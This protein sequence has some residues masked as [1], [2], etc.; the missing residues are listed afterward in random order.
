MKNNKTFLDS[1]DLKNL[2]TWLVHQRCKLK[3]GGLETIKQ[4]KLKNLG[5][6]ENSI[7]NEQWNKMFLLL[8][9]Y[10]EN[11]GNCNVPDEYK[12][13][14][15]LGKWVGWQR[16]LKTWGKLS[17][18]RIGRLT[19]LGFRWNLYKDHWDEMYRSLVNF[20]KE[21]GHCDIPQDYPDNQKL[22]TWVGSRRAHRSKLSTDEVKK[23][24]GIGFIWDALDYQWK[25]KYSVLVKYKEINGNCNIPQD[26]LLSVWV[27][28][29][30]VMRRR[31]TLSKE[32]ISAL[33]K[34]GFQWEPHSSKWEKQYQ[35]LINFKKTHGHCDVPHSYP[36]DLYLGVW[37][38]TQ[39]S[40]RKSGRLKSDRVKKLNKLGFRWEYEKEDLFKTKFNELVKFKTTHGHCNVPISYTKNKSLAKWVSKRRARKDSLS[41]EN[42]SLLDSLGFQWKLLDS[43]WESQYQKLANFKNKN[44]HCNVP[45]SFKENNLGVWAATQRSR[46]K[47]GTMLKDQFKKLNDIG[48]EWSPKETFLDSTWDIRFEEL[49]K[50]HACFGHC[51]VP[52]RFPENQTL[53]TWVSNLRNRADSKTLS[54]DKI[55]KL[56]SLNFDW[57]PIENAWNKAYSRLVL[58]HKKNGHCLVPQ[59]YPE[60]QSLG[61]WVSRQRRSKNSLSSS[62]VKLLESLG[63]VWSAIRN[64]WESMYQEL[65]KFKVRNIHCKVPIVYIENP[66]L[67]RWVAIQRRRQKLN[68]ISSGEVK[69][70]NSIG[71][72]WNGL[73]SID[74]CWEEM[75]LKLK[76]Y[77][78][79]HGNCNAPE[80][81]ENRRSLGSWCQRQRSCKRKGIIEKEKENRLTVLGFDWNP[82][83]TQFDTMFDKL[84]QYKK[85]YGNCDLLKKKNKYKKLLCWTITLR[86][87]YKDGHLNKDRIKRLENIGFVWNKDEAFSEKMYQALIQFKKEHGNCRVPQRY[88]KNLHLGFWVSNQR[89]RYKK[90]IMAP[91]LKRKLNALNFEWEADSRVYCLSKTNSAWNEIVKHLDL[92]KLP[93][94]I[95]SQRKSILAKKIKAERLKKLNDLGFKVA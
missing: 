13:N 54:R 2:S 86:Q 25:E 50:F 22:A 17:K 57:S 1:L 3:N 67:G 73:D 74:D 19:N 88:K 36:E 9:G 80:T 4:E 38:T 7:S 83:I 71:F 49:K 37:V 45:Q 64:R 93:K 94:W 6:K 35:E 60:D 82:S 40:K 23:L 31:R 26:H 75:F 66:V 27:S 30:R 81:K 87:S 91:E 41:K 69:K 52:Q 29:Q 28:A 46:N 24:N 84:K 20:K 18:D 76:Q 65:I 44:G 47:K 5:V 42:I 10:K 53:A 72:V 63:F 8:S 78:K 90:G 34:L 39:R 89:A 32:K 16:A 33:N 59:D 92:K 58:F 61:K 95:K 14:K 12:E 77:K 51:R 48:F 21:K 11:N 56:E 79:R 85:V 15:S 43:I 70:L 62:Q 68:T 55:A